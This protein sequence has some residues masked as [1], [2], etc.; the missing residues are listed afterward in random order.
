MISISIAELVHA[1]EIFI[2][3][4]TSQYFNEN[5]RRVL[6]TQLN[7]NESELA[8]TI[9]RKYREEYKKFADIGDEKSDTEDDGEWWPINSSLYVGSLL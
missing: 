8:K 9:A 6:S 2:R 5:A 3:E 7:G 4:K 1:L